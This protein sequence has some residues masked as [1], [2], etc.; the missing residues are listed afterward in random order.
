MELAHR[1]RGWAVGLAALLILAAASSLN[2]FPDYLAYSNEAFGGPSQSYR[3]FAGANGDWAQ[4]LKWVKS[5]LNRTQTSDCWFDYTDPDVDPKYYGIQ[6]RP[7]L[8]A[9]V[10]ADI[11]YCGR[12]RPPSVERC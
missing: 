10:P 11:P 12:F 7:L 8:T 5:Y 2:A 9:W 6:C 1:S 4:S 3:L